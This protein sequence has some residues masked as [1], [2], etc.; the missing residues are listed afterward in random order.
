MQ[1][2]QP[3]QNSVPP[4]RTTSSAST[5]PY[6]QQTQQPPQ[7]PQSQQQQHPI[8][9]SQ[10]RNNTF[11][12]PESK[13]NGRPGN[14]S[15]Q[16]PPVKHEVSVVELLF[17]N[18]E[19][20]NFKLMT[21]F[22]LQAHVNGLSQQNKMQQNGMRSNEQKFPTA[23][24]GSMG[25]PLSNGISD[26]RFIKPRNVP[27]ERIPL[28]PPASPYTGQK[29]ENILKMMTSTAALP[30]IG[31]IG[32]TPRTE[33]E[34]QQPNKSHVYAELPSSCF[35]TLSKRRKYLAYLIPTSDN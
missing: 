13:Y 32:A 12:K 18:I 4:N 25:P 9:S 5:H 16:Q 3:Y 28:E 34:D 33:I 22:I 27:N 23:T 14:Y 21:H 2:Q 10:T 1:Q 29:I 35:K 24:S 31:G 26:D 19:L 15:G 17:Y 7:V 8:A 11:L 30:I 20:I 6:N